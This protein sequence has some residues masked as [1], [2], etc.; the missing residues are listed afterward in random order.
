MKHVTLLII[1]CVLVSCELLWKFGFNL[2]MFQ[3]DSL[4]IGKKSVV[5]ITVDI[6]YTPKYIRRLLRGNSRHSNGYLNNQQK[7]TIK[8]TI[9]QKPKLLYKLSEALF[10]R[11]TGTEY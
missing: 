4:L 9:K 5:Q 10:I 7:L 8:S 1:T 2:V 6:N 11:K 3:I